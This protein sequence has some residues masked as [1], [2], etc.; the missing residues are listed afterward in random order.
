[1]VQH[2]TYVDAFFAGKLEPDHSLGLCDS[3]L[4]AELVAIRQYDVV[5]KMILILFFYCEL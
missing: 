3:L 5:L 4:V 1:M 2:A